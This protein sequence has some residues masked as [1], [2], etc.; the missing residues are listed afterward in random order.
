VKGK[1]PKLRIVQGAIG[2][3]ILLA[4]LYSVK[5]DIANLKKVNLEM[6]ALSVLM[7]DLLNVILAYRVYYLLKKM[8][9]NP[10]FSCVFLAN[11]GGMV[12]GDVTPGRSG[13]V[14]MAKLLDRCGI[15]VSDG[16]AAV[17]APQ[18]IDFVVKG[19]GASLAIIVLGFSRPWA[20][21][22]VVAVGGVILAFMWHEKPLEF[23]KS[24]TPS[25][26]FRVMDRFGLTDKIG[27]ILSNTVRSGIETRKYAVQILALCLL[28][29][30][31]VGLQW[32]FVGKAC[33]VIFPFYVYFLLQPL[34]SAL[35]FV[36]ITPAGLGVMETGTVLVLYALGINPAKATVFAI[37]I[38]LSYI[39]ADLPGVF[40]WLKS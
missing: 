3:A 20:G 9:Y 25:F 22:I 33:D 37:M 7:Y 19:V 38:R 1:I 4:L 15:P 34:L 14:S 39:C 21:L 28:G 23:L 26:A 17:V 24:V 29:W 11:L 32:F 18:G 2:L 35:T 8:G 13:Y 5:G 12:A 31:I 16:M 10:R 27:N 40:A 6:F 36:P 30:V